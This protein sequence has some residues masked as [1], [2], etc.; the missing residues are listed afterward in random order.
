M[1][2]VH[3]CLPPL[4]QPQTRNWASS[5]FPD[6]PSTSPPHFFL[7]C[8]SAPLLPSLSSS[9]S[10]I[11]PVIGSQLTSHVFFKWADPSPLA[12]SSPLYNLSPFPFPL[13]SPLVSLSF[14]STSYPNTNPPQLTS[15]TRKLLPPN[16]YKKRTPRHATSRLNGFTLTLIIFH[17]YPG[18]GFFFSWGCLR[19]VGNGTENEGVTGRGFALRGGK[20]HVMRR[21]AWVGVVVVVVRQGVGSLTD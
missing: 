6:I 3:R 16:G 15:R 18:L 4:E 11:Y 14:N 8:F 12:V 2:Y 7:L 5:F 21:G 9:S 20:G 13:F 17:Q 19:W 1:P 10:S